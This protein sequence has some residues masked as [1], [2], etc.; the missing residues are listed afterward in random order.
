MADAAP[1]AA[2]R[3]TASCFTD[4]ML[5]ETERPRAVSG[6]LKRSIWYSGLEYVVKVMPG[7]PPIATAEANRNKLRQCCGNQKAYINQLTLLVMLYDW[8]TNLYALQ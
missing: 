4:N 7:E 8:L 3:R 5:A 2:P 6:I 1:R